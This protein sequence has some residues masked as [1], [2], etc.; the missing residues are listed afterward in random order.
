[1]VKRIITTPFLMALVILLLTS[2]GPDELLNSV[3][4]KIKVTV[5]A[6]ALISPPLP[7][8][9]EAI[10]DFTKNG[11]ERFTITRTI[12]S[13]GTCEN[14]AVTYD[15][16]PG[17]IID[18]KASVQGR[19]A[20]AR[21]IWTSS[22]SLQYYRAESNAKKDAQ[23]NST[24]VWSTQLTLIAENFGQ[25]SPPGTSVTIS[26][27]TTSTTTTT[28]LT[29]SSTTTITTSTTTTT[30]KVVSRWDL[31]GDWI[32]KF[33]VDG[34]NSYNHDYFIVQEGG[35]I[36]GSGGVPAGGKYDNRETFT[37]TNGLTATGPITIHSVYENGTYYYDLTGTID[38][39]GRISGTWIDN[40]NPVHKGTFSTIEGAAIPVP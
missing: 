4:K 13:D 8:A 20:S 17:E 26:T 24:F 37:G 12:P 14:A 10:F 18:V 38:E 33:R 34:G 40:Y 23:G 27:A 1:M 31:T 11:G 39:D 28:P 7:Y 15:L 29:T 25:D 32:I 19:E 22:D 9:A 35:S 5:Q 36:T 6:S 30:K 16:Y 21:T 2:C 3:T